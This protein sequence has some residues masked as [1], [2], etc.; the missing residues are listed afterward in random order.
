MLTFDTHEHKNVLNIY[1]HTLSQTAF[2]DVT[3]TG[4]IHIEDTQQQAMHTALDVCTLEVGGRRHSEI[5]GAMPGY[6]VPCAAI[7]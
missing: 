1:T 4:S 5:G 3:K 2:M 6:S 7:Q